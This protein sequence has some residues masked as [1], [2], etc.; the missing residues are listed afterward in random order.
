MTFKQLLSDVFGGPSAARQPG[1][2]GPQPGQQQPVQ[3]GPFQQQPAQQQP[4][5]APAVEQP[6][7]DRSWAQ[8]GR[9]ATV[10]LNL[11][12]Q[13]EG[14]APPGGAQPGFNA[15]QGGYDAPHEAPASPAWSAPAGGTG[16]AQPGPRSPTT[17]KRG[18]WFGAALVGAVAAGLC[19]LVGLIVVGSSVAS[20]KQRLLH[21][22]DANKPGVAIA[23]QAEVAYCTK[24]FKQVLERVLHSC[25]L[26]TQAE[27]R[28]CKPADI[29]NFA[30]INDQ[31]FNALFHP[32]KDRGG[33]LLFEEGSDA[34]DSTAKKL[35]DERWFD[36]K[37]AR[38]FFV[39]ARASKTGTAD[40]NRALSHRRANSVLFYLKEISGETEEELNQKVGLLWLGNEYAQLSEE[41]CTWPR[42]G[43]DEKCGAEAINRSAFVSWVDCRL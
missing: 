4:A 16:F 18:T 40:K 9:G 33:V 15:P 38:Y 24:D 25:G 31:D 6:V 37:G 13:T 12:A 11:G 17:A 20:A 32:L 10:P 7:D 8:Q 43:G 41:Y 19:L 23:Q 22:E 34:L 14:Y 3:Q 30:A 36:R 5:A 28:G 29:R 27:R 2:G 26:S 39:V 21:P 42:S 35:L 1:T